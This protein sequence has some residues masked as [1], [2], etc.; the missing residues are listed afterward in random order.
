MK[1]VMLLFLCVGFMFSC[2]NTN[3]NKTID[4]LIGHFR[5]NGFQGQK[6]KKLFQMVG[7]IDGCG[8]KG[9]NINVE[10]YKYNSSENIPQMLPIR[11][12][13]FG[14]MIHGDSDSESNKKLIKIFKNF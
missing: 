9:T 4:D 1:K 10:I 2:G 8:I 7:A 14:M 13:N 11:N 12:G 3:K 6:E 5:E